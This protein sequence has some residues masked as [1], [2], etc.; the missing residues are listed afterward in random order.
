MKGGDDEFIEVGYEWGKE[1]KEGVLWDEGFWKGVGGEWVIDVME[2]GLV[3]WREVIELENV[4]V[5]RVVVI[6][7]DGGVGVLWLGEVELGVY[8]VVCL[9]EKRVWVGFGFVDE[10]GGEVKVNRGELEFV[11]RCEG[12]DVIVEGSGWVG[13]DI[14]GV[15]VFRNVLEYVLRRGGGMRC[16]RVDNKVV[17]LKGLKEGVEGVVVVEREICVGVGVVNG[18]NE[19]GNKWEGRGIRKEVVVC[20]VGMKV[21]RVY[22]VVVEVKVIGV[23]VF[24]VGCGE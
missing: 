6:C 3:G 14:E 7:K 9:N 24:E 15:G 11:G 20:R 1:K 2:D 22:E 12:K 17:V 8:G 13:R 16:E 10:N 18:E 23:G 4:F 21:V 19:V 5:G